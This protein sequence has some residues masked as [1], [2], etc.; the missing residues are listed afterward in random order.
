MTPAFRL[1]DADPAVFAGMF[2]GTDMGAAPLAEALSLD[3]RSADSS[4]IAAMVVALWMS[5][6]R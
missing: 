1:L 3:P 6:G 2:M 4:G 5:K